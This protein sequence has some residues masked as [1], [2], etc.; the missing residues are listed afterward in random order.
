MEY[1]IIFKP[2]K[3]ITDNFRKAVIERNSKIE[4]RDWI[5]ND[6]K[7][8]RIGKLNPDN[9][10]L[11]PNSD[12]NVKPMA[13]WL[14]KELGG[15]VFINPEPEHSEFRTSD[16]MYRNQKWELKT[17]KSKNKNTIYYQID[18]GKGQAN[19]FIIDM[20]QTEFSYEEVLEQVNF[21]FSAKNIKWFN[22]LIV[23]HNKHNK[24]GVFIRN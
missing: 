24:Y 10:R 12:E 22:K 8:Y 19:N 13:E 1:K 9:V 16:F 5:K 21:A 17:P 6:G 4:E 7:V 15:K 11:R 14:Q 3:N 20:S 23:K 2:Y 18:S